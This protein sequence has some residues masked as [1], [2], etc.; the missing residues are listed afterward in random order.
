MT[1]AAS[2]PI[3][4]DTEMAL[5]EAFGSRRSV[6]AGEYLY[7]AGDT[8]YDFFVVL[9]GSVDIILDVDGEEQVIVTHGPG[10]F[11]GELNLLSGLRVFVS[12]RVAAPSELLAIPVEALRRIIA[13]EPLLSDKILATFMARRAELVTGA[14][15]AT[16]VIGSRYSTEVLQ[17]R[18]F[19]T[20]TRIPHQWLDPDEDP[21]VETILEHFDMQ[22]SDLPVAIASGKV[23]RRAT[24]GELAEYLGLTVSTTRPPSSRRASVQEARSSLPA[25][26]TRRGRR[27]YSSPNRSVRSPLS[28]A[29]RTSAPT[30]PPTLSTA[31]RPTR[32]STS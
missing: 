4:D 17:L 11:L 1:D 21:H 3:F 12:A 9:S 20:R 7:R 27:R 5:V 2:V 19:L 8:G 26:A 30:C 14:G 28:S 32:G 29:A 22:P 23:L 24:A 31:S 6:R 13:T 10:R 18:E 15:A 16:R 25:A